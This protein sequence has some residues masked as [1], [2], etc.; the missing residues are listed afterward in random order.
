M[1]WLVLIVLTLVGASASYLA[2]AA[3]LRD[4]STLDRL[5]ASMILWIVVRLVAIQ[6]TGYLG[7]LWPL[8]LGLTSLALDLGL[9]FVAWRA[10]PAVD[11]RRLLR[12]DLGAPW[13][14]ASDFVRAPEPAVLVVLPALF[15]LCVAVLSAWYFRSWSWDGLWYHSPIT[16]FAVQ[17]GTLAW[18]STDDFFIQGYP[19]NAELLSTWACVFPR[20]MR[21]EDATQIPFGVLG[22]LVIAAWAR[23]LSAPRALALGVGAAWLAFPP[24]YLELGTSYID[25]A[26]GALF[27]TAFYFVSGRFDVRDLALA[28]IA[29]GLYVGTKFSGA[30]H[31]AFLAPVVVLRFLPHLVRDRGS[32]VR[33][34][35]WATGA[36]VLSLAVA[37]PK[38]VQNWVVAGNPLWPFRTHLPVIGQLDGPEFVERLYDAPEG[39]PLSFFRLPGDFMKLMDSWTFPWDQAVF[40]PDLRNGGFGAVFRWMLVPC[41]LFVLGDA[42]RLR[43]AS[44]A[45]PIALLFALSLVVP[46]AWWPR[47]TYGAGVAGLLAFALVHPQV[48]SRL[49]RLAASTA[50]AAF[51]LFDFWRVRPSVVQAPFAEHF[52]EARR[53]DAAQRNSVEFGLMWPHRWS[54]ARETELRPGDVVAYDESVLFLGEFFTSDYRTSV[55]YVPS[56]T[57][58][59][60]F[61]ARVR[62]ARARWVGVRAGSYAAAD[63]S[64][65]GGRLLFQTGSTA[66]YE[67]PW[68]ATP[69]RP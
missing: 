32:R 67:T 60:T 61:V 1:G 45:A 10:L 4:R 53:G 21:L 14:L 18:P 26:C 69:S 24:V 42:I 11:L 62:R 63:L 46:A 25:V 65:A 19:R 47:Y 55:V 7:A 28:M 51:I 44:R 16:H 23:R 6:A 41:V 30:F 27:V 35:L 33:L 56:E 52:A 66:I 39:T 48:R 59:R 50:F 49:L 37:I 8:Q 15:M 20:D 17:N 31:A 29:L 64:R 58:P 12:H 57:E 22:A 2:A 68:S 13:R 34:A 9:V 40:T 36:T 38:Y 3:A 43:A 54:L 5:V